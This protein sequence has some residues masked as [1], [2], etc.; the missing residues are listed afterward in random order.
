M[1][2]LGR[3]LERLLRVDRAEQWGADGVGG[4]RV[5]DTAP[6]LMLHGMFRR[7]KQSKPRNH[8]MRGCDAHL[9]H[10]F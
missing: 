1:C 10:A 2:Q 6:I 8:A 7:A 4:A 9:M 5:V 3:C